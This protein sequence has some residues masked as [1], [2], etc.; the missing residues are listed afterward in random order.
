M[1]EPKGGTNVLRYMRILLYI[2]NMF[3]TISKAIVCAA[4]ER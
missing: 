3:Y 2:G 4:K 1:L